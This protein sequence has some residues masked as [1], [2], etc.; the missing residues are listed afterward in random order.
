MRNIIMLVEKLLPSIENGIVF[1]NN[2]GGP[3]S[4]GNGIRDIW[5]LQ[6]RA[7]LENMQVPGCLKCWQQS[8]VASPAL[9]FRGPSNIDPVNRN[10]KM[11]LACCMLT[12]RDRSL[13]AT[14]PDRS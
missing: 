13:L 3:T 5:F 11:R 8:L 9:N 10:C 6:V 12:G 2:P 4:I 1:K 14:T 7:L